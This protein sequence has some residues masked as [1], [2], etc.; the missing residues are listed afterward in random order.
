MAIT[1]Q[2]LPSKMDN[3]SSFVETAHSMQNQHL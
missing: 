2:L 3:A 1:S